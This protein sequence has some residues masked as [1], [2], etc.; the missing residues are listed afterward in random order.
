MKPLR[1][2]LVPQ[3]PPFSISFTDEIFTVG[4]CFAEAMGRLFA[5]NKF[6]IQ[7]NPFGTVYNPVS[8]H[9]LLHHCIHSK[10]ADPAGN[11][12]RD[13]AYYHHD[14]HSRH[15]A[16][17]VDELQKNLERLIASQ[18]QHIRQ[19]SV[20]ILTYGTAWVY[21]SITSGQLVANCHKVPAVQFKKELLTVEQVVHDFQKIRQDLIAI[22]PNIKIILTVSPVRHI[23][24]G[25]EH[26]TVSKSILR[27]A[28]HAL[29]QEKDIAY[30]PSYELMIDD[31]RDYRFYKTDRIHPSEE[32][33]DYMWEKFAEAYFGEPAKRM[34]AEWQEILS[35]LQHKP[36]QP[37]ST[38]HQQFLQ[39]TLL[40]LKGVE[41]YMDVR[42]EIAELQSRMYA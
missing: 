20:L 26:N 3:K 6:K 34:L 4:S 13:G 37:Q 19:A 27:L 42:D 33:E 2:E 22:N 24:D 32:A 31:L 21:R 7:A 41:D 30:F 11:V 9:R 15:V 14:F 18:N 35:A 40:R 39:K 29:A 16:S 1:T 25:A 17:S 8:I 28:C 10:P 38:A 23:K 36:F 5:I 12:W